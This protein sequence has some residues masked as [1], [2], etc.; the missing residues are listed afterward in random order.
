MSKEA[1][2]SYIALARKYRPNNFSQLIGQET[3]VTTIS[4]AIKKDRLHHAYILTGIRGIGK[5]TTARIIAKAFNC[6][7]EKNIG[8]ENNFPCGEC[9][10]CKL[11]ANSTHQDV[12]EFDAASRTGVDDIREIISS[13]AYA[14]VNSK[15][16]IYIID[17]VHMLSNNAFNALLKTLEEPPS[18]VKF[19]FA[20]TE[21]KKV[22]ITILSRCQRFDLRRLSEDEIANHLENILTQENFS[23]EKSALNLIAKLSEGSVRDAL[24]ILDQALSNNNFATNLEAQTV[25]KMLNLNDKNQVLELFST[26]IK[27]DFAACVAQF[28][29]FYSY[30]CDVSSLV[31]DLMEINYKITSAKLIPNYNLD[32]YSSLQQQQI[33]EIAAEIPLGSLTKIWQMLMKGNSE[34]QYSA[35]AKTAF[36]ML[37][38][39]ICH[40]Q[41]LP[42]LKIILKNLDD[43]KS[44][45]KNTTQNFSTQNKQNNLDFKTEDK[46]NQTNQ[47]ND[48]LNEVLRNFSGAKIVNQ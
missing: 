2:K 36:I 5:T 24:S 18:H 27:S 40:L 42:N 46:S 11:I 6:E 20:T 12:I 28:E 32:D 47:D 14:P 38:A 29:K 48:V 1:Q 37:L 15:Y 34:I 45:A 33:R 41:S 22:P 25:E 8:S 16:K 31:Q 43:E 7:V 30:S 10:N 44:V 26:M 23:A 3:L 17:E 4:N 19:I 21:I 9:Q 39:R 13:I 35:N